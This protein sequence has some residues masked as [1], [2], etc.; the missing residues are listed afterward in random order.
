MRI[1]DESQAEKDSSDWTHQ[2]VHLSHHVEIQ[3]NTHYAR[4]PDAHSRTVLHD[5]HSDCLLY[6]DALAFV[7]PL[8]FLP[9]VVVISVTEA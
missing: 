9:D 6:F 2:A 4:C 3:Q 5:T 8:C 1:L 7:N